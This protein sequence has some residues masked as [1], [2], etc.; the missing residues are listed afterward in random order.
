MTFAPIAGVT[1]IGIGHKARQGKDTVC[2][3]MIEA[4]ASSVKRYAFADAMKMYCRLF[5][6]MTTKNSEMLQRIG[7]EKR[8]ADPWFWIK[9]LYWN[10]EEQRPR[11]A[12]IS[13]VRLRTEAAFVKNLGGI[14]VNVTRYENGQPYVDPSRP[15]T[16]VTESEMDGYDYDYYLRN[17][18]QLGDLVIAAQELF[19]LTRIMR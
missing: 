8:Q 9:Q 6:G 13:D 3:A 11:F 7:T 10:I 18:R 14:V 15:A 19:S 17:D 12:V 1:V 16:H 4:D 2:Q 5:H